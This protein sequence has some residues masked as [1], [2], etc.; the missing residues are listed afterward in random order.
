MAR[1]P[2][3]RLRS[4]TKLRPV[5][6][7][8]STMTE[9][10]SG[11]RGRQIAEALGSF[12]PAISQMQQNYVAEQNRKQAQI[13]R[14]DAARS[15]ER[16]VT[17]TSKINELLSQP[18]NARLP[19]EEFLKL[20][21]VTELMNSS[22]E[23]FSTPE[24]A[25][26]LQARLTERVS[27][28]HNARFLEQGQTDRLDAAS[29]FAFFTIEDNI[30]LMKAQG[31]SDEEINAALGPIL[32]AI[33]KTM[34]EQYELSNSQKLE[35]WKSIQSRR[36][37][38]Q[39]DAFV[40]E[41]VLGQTWGGKDF[42]EDITNAVYTARNNYK[43]EKL[44]Q[45]Q[46]MMTPY[47]KAAIF[48]EL[49][50]AQ[51]AEMD[52]LVEQGFFTQAEVEQM[53]VVNYRERKQLQDAQVTAAAKNEALLASL[54]SY[55]QDGFFSD[56]TYTTADGSTKTITAKEIERQFAA[57]LNRKFGDDISALVMAF[58]AHPMVK[59]PKWESLSRLWVTQVGAGD[60]EGAAESLATFDA[61][62]ELNPAVARNHMSDKNFT[63]FQDY[64]ALR[65]QFGPERAVTLMVNAF[66]DNR[67]EVSSQAAGRFADN[68]VAELP[69]ENYSEGIR[70]WAFEHYKTVGKYL[71]M[72]DEELIER[73]LPTI[74]AASA[75]V[76]GQPVFTMG[77]NLSSLGGKEAFQVTAENYLKHLT[78]TRTM[79]SGY[80]P[81]ML[82]LFVD[83]RRPNSFGVLMHGIPAFVEPIT[84]ETLTTFAR[85][86]M[87][88]E[89]NQRLEEERVAYELDKKFREEEELIGPIMGP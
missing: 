22:V 71:H 67:P 43:A 72:S 19:S 69:E 10:A 58:N 33:D 34:G 70:A 87:S 20:P 26:L 28:L 9:T 17:A 21:E 37:I 77:I 5:Q 55:T 81:E 75:E 27:G 13:D 15:Q 39:K 12:S 1:N 25:Q 47:Q 24:A 83:P 51:E 30:G 59:N 6:G 40:G 56:T 89:A 4:P 46:S 8:S 80:D 31:K 18:E 29:Q 41:W 7:V 23:G 3:G 82:T 63:L 48:G 38:D 50:P 54:D 52:A 65:S 16:L 86:G 64:R 62:Y 76:N 49:T 44:A 35:M 11:S 84:I 2:N 85:N 14:L 79:F 66:T 78:K 42:K 45:G 60:V 68:L 73:M 36:A 74:E 32:G 53:K 61:V 57:D 88:E